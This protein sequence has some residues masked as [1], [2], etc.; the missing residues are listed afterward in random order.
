LLKLIS[1][2]AFER[3]S[4]WIIA[5][6]R[7]ARRYVFALTRLQ[8][9]PFAYRG[10]ERICARQGNSIASKPPRPV[11]H[12][13]GPV[14]LYRWATFRLGICATYLMSC[15]GPRSQDDRNRARY[16]SCASVTRQCSHLKNKDA[17]GVLTSPCSSPCMCVSE[18]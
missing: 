11:K 7:V 12:P 5:C 14:P 3:T 1:K 18:A 16:V 17:G 8:K 10:C 6:V 9:L 15:T 13:S 4:Q 2:S